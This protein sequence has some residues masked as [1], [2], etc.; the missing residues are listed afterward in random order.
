MRAAIISISLFA[1]IS[2]TA[3][4]IG[5]PAPMYKGSR[6]CS[7]QQPV[8]V[9]GCLKDGASP[10]ACHLSCGDLHRKCLA[11]GCWVSVAFRFCGLV[12]Q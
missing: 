12:K 6:T 9:D 3:T 11:D 7:Q 2:V 10:K 1:L 4:A 8:C 5:Q